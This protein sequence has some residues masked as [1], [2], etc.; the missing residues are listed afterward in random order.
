MLVRIQ[1]NEEDIRFSSQFGCSFTS[2]S[3]TLD[4]APSWFLVVSCCIWKHQLQ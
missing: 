4:Q 1:N 2:N 3:L